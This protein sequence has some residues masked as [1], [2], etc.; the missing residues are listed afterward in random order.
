VGLTDQDFCIYLTFRTP[1]PTI[2]KHLTEY[3]ICWTIVIAHCEQQYYSD[4]NMSSEIPQHNPIGIDS[5]TKLIQ[6]LN[7][8]I[9]LK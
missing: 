2:V 9:N 8:I 3:T 6:L 4:L 5:I 7:L 1:H